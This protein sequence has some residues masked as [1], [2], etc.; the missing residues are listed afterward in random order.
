[1]IAGG[2]GGS[3]SM[4]LGRGAQSRCCQ[5]DG[6]LVSRQPETM[7]LGSFLHDRSA[8]KSSVFIDSTISYAHDESDDHEIEYVSET[9]I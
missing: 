3:C 8:G 4:F 6:T 7:L 2:R 9:G 1:M 5:G